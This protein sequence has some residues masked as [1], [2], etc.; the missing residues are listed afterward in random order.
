MATAIEVYEKL[1]HKLG[2]EEAKL[3]VEFVEEETHK[4]TKKIETVE[5]DFL[6]ILSKLEGIET[7]QIR[8]EN[9]LDLLEQ[10]ISS[11]EGIETKQIRLENKLDLLEQKISSLEERTNNLENRIWWLVGL[12]IIQWLSLMAAILFKH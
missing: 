12:T 11:L 7:K 6:K 9:K 4:R 8:L 1:R 10:K 3:L 5:D 2:E